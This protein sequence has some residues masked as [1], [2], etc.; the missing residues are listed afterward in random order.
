MASPD[1]Q[2]RIKDATLSVSAALANAANLVNTNSMDLGLAIP[3][4]VTE[5]VVAL[6]ETTAGNGAN[7]KN[8]NFALQDSADNTTFTNLA[9]IGVMPILT[10]AD[11]AGG[12]YNA[13]AFRIPLATTVKRYLRASSKGEANG[14]DASN[15]TLTLSLVF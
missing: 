13:T 15:G 6:L 9:N 2:R 1:T 11:N 7:S 8:L 3:Y 10:I 4:P 14:G 5:C 12:G